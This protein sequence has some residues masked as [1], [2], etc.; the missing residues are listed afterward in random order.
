M[1]ALSDPCAGPN[2][3]E[4]HESDLYL[5]AMIFSMTQ[6]NAHLHADIVA[7]KS[8]LTLIG[9]ILIENGPLTEWAQRRLREA[10]ATPENDYVGL[11]S[12]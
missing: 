4:P 11:D 10:R 9:N 8:E 3:R 12:L 6:Q 1:V 5:P 2:T 7:I